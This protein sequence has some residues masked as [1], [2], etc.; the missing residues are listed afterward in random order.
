M[1]FG[2]GSATGQSAGLPPTTTPI[3]GATTTAAKSGTY[4]PPP[5][6]MPLPRP[7]PFPEER[8]IYQ[9]EGLDIR[10]DFG[11]E[12]GVVA[13]NAARP[14]ENIVL[15]HTD[16]DHDLEWYVDYGHRYDADRYPPGSY[17]YHFYIGPDGEMVQGAPLTVRVNGATGYDGVLSNTSSI[18][19]AMIGTQN[20]PQQVAAATALTAALMSDLE[21]EPW[22]IANHGVL[23][24]DQGDENP[25]IAELENESIWAVMENVGALAHNILRPGRSMPPF[26]ADSRVGIAQ[27]ALNDWL[28]STGQHARLSADGQFGPGTLATVLEFQRA[29]GIPPTG[30]V[31][32]PTQQELARHLLA[33]N[34][35]FAGLARVREWWR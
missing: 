6:T 13:T 4:V 24:E 15:H 33:D 3:F 12:Y 30:F 1:Q 23:K 34:P 16:D 9:H 35:A 11:G 2:W 18:H 17:G 7:R 27:A 32:P 21:I 10:P 8:G 19:I 28:V 20:T 31:D 25:R 14:L 29:T 26:E 5:G 22:R